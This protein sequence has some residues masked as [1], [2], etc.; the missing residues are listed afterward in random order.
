MFCNGIQLMNTPQ[1]SS[2]FLFWMEVNCF[3]NMCNPATEAKSVLYTSKRLTNVWITL[4][5]RPYCRGRVVLCAVTLCHN[6]LCGKY[7]GIYI[8]VCPVTWLINP[9]DS[10]WDQPLGHYE[11]TYSSD[12]NA[13]KDLKQRIEIH[14]D[15]LNLTKRQTKGWTGRG[16]DRVTKTEPMTWR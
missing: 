2:F 4:C 3:L 9:S 1:F 7:M 5:W 12:K 6:V 15:K 8:Q 10:A 14:L 11:L 13:K 16:D